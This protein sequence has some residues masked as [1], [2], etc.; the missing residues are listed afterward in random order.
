MLDGGHVKAGDSLFLVEQDPRRVSIAFA[1]RIYHY[2]RKNREGIEKVLGS[3]PFG[4]MAEIISGIKRTGIALFRPAAV[5]A[6]YFLGT[7]HI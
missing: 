2:D 3:R 1:N 6:I 5:V 4:I 7:L